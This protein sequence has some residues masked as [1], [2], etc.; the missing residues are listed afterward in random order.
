MRTLLVNDK[1][2]FTGGKVAFISGQ[3]VITQIKVSISRFWACST[4]SIRLAIPLLDTTAPMPLAPVYPEMPLAI[5]MGYDDTLYN[6]L[7]ANAQINRVFTGYV[8]TVTYKFTPD[9]II[10][11]IALRD[12]M[13][14]LVNNKITRMFTGVDIGASQVEGGTVISGKRDDI[15][16]GLILD[17]AGSFGKTNAEGTPIADADRVFTENRLHIAVSN[18]NE[19]VHDTATQLV[20]SGA[21]GQAITTGVQQY[22]NVMNRFPIEVIKHLS[23]LEDRPMEFYADQY[24]DLHWAPRAMD[25]ETQKPRDYYFRHPV[26]ID[27]SETRGIHQILMGSMEW[28]TLGT[29]TEFVVVNPQSQDNAVLAVSGRIVPD[30]IFG[31]PM[32]SRTRFVFDDTLSNKDPGSIRNEATD[33]LLGMLQL[34]GK[35]VRGGSIEV[36]GDTSVYPGDPIRLWGTGLYPAPENLFR[37]ESVIHLLTADGPRKGLRTSILFSEPEYKPKI[38]EEWIQGTA[39]EYISEVQKA[40]AKPDDPQ[41]SEEGSQKPATP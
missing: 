24:G 2:D 13:R 35:D 36:L 33:F 30:K 34:W 12:S 22:Y 28:S 29:V 32:A 6:L 10:C 3:W 16:R 17:G 38:D 15:V 5:A 39:F 31:F 27:A 20:Q 41:S 7:G 14:F 8:D 26:A 37:V 18:R 19:I 9:Q 21:T 1:G 25:L 11:T 4:A 23:S 40:P